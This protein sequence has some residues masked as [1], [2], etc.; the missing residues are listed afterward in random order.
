MCCT[1]QRLHVHYCN[2]DG[3]HVT[4]LHASSV[5]VVAVRIVMHFTSRCFCV[6]ACVPTYV[7]V[8][9]FKLCVSKINI[10]Y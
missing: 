4:E 3:D 9:I 5:V 7:C 10:I 6:R 1:I 8:S 2:D